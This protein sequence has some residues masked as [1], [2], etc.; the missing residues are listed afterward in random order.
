M[1][2]SDYNKYILNEAITDNIKNNLDRKIG[3]LNQK[4]NTFQ[5][6]VSEDLVLYTADGIKIRLNENYYTLLTY[7]GDKKKKYFNQKVVYKISIIKANYSSKKLMFKLVSSQVLGT[8]DQ[9]NPT[10]DYA[11]DLSK[12]ISGDEIVS[13]IENI[14]LIDPNFNFKKLSRNDVAIIDGNL[15]PKTFKKPENKTSTQPVQNITTTTTTTVA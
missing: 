6:K 5:K 8:I 10:V 13:D 12:G 4:I 9:N 7:T 14:N 2:Y 15:K 11:E 3:D 1:I